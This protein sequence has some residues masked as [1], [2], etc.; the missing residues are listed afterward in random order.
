M[1]I[2]LSFCFF[3]FSFGGLEKVLVVVFKKFFYLGIILEVK[4]IEE[5]SGIVGGIRY[6]GSV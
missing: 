6:I 5:F 4:R 2:W 1:E 3:V